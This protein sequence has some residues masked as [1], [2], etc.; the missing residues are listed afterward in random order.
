MVV[1][2]RDASASFGAGA[3]LLAIAGGANEW[4]SCKPQHCVLF[5][6]A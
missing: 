3:A 4:P 1:M 2:F 6:V 5:G